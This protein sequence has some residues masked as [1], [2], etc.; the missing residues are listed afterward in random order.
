MSTKPRNWKLLRSTTAYKSSHLTV[1]RDR[2]RKPDGKTYEHMVVVGGRVVAIL[3]LTDQKEVMLV[4]QFRPAVRRF[5]LDLPGGGIE[6]NESPVAAARRELQEE[7]GYRAEKM[8]LLATYFSDSGRSDQIRY[9]FL[10]GRLVPGKQSD[11]P[12]EKIRV[13][14]MPLTRL[15]QRKNLDENTLLTALLLYQHKR[16]QSRSARTRS[17]FLT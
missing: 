4:R 15:A 11:N 1:R 3:A 6:R 13:V 9:I 10:A 17:E 7:T 14:H 12:D 8:T 5:T 16:G 2:F